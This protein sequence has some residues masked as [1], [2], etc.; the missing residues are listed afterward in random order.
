[1]K[2]SLVAATCISSAISCFLM[3]FLANMP[4]AVAPGMGINAY[5]TYQVGGGVCCVCQGDGGGLFATLLAGARCRDQGVWSAGSSSWHGAAPWRCSSR[6]ATHCQRTCYPS[7]H[8][9]APTHLPASPA[10][11]LF[12]SMP[13]VLMCPVC[14]PPPSPSCVPAPSGGGVPWHWARDL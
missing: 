3:A 8:P 9:A 1:V 10:P 11:S 2:Q 6:Q 14:A 4:L 13:C 12:S 7:T 5:F